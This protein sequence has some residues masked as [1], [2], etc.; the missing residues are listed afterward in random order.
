M[1]L[2]PVLYPIVN[3][4]YFQTLLMKLVVMVCSQSSQVVR[5]KC[6][7]Q[8]QENPIQQL[9]RGRTIMLDKKGRER[10]TVELVYN[11]LRSISMEKIRPRGIPNS[12]LIGAGR[13]HGTMTGPT[14]IVG[15]HEDVMGHTVGSPTVV[16]KWS[17]GFGTPPLIGGN[18]V[19]DGFSNEGGFDSVCNPGLGVGAGIRCAV[20]VVFVVVAVV[21]VVVVAMFGIVVGVAIVD[22][23]VDIDDWSC[24]ILIILSGLSDCLLRRR[25]YLGSIVGFVP[26]VSTTDLTKATVKFRRSICAK[27]TMG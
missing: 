25:P 8:Y 11:H 26:P 20:G 2:P 21:V 24:V 14:M 4:C 23:D 19:V 1:M 10:Q 7:F 3:D 27:S 15:V 12:C 6:P 9:K 16:G 17:N 5:S 22:V 13:G 18:N